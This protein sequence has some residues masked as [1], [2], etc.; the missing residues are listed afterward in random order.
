MD[1]KKKIPEIYNSDKAS[2]KEKVILGLTASIDS[3][4]S[5][6]LLKV[7][8]YELIALT[9]V[10]DWAPPELSSEKNFSCFISQDRLDFLKSFCHH[11]NIPHYIDKISLDFKDS[12][13]DP[14]IADKIVGKKSHACWNCHELRLS[15]LDQKR[16]EF[17][18]H[19]IATG[20][21]AKV[22]KRDQNGTVFV[23]SSNDPEFDQSQK[24]S[25][26]P[27]DILKH[28]LLPLSDLTRK[29][30]LKLAENFAIRNESIS[31]AIDFCFSPPPFADELITRE[32]PARFLKDG[33]VIS[34]DESVHFGQHDEMFRYGIGEIYPIKVGVQQVENH[35]ASFSLVDKKI[36]LIEGSYFSRTMHLLVNCHISQEV[37][38]SEPTK[39]FILFESEWTECLVTQ[40]TLQ[41]VSLEFE[42]EIKL[43]PGER[44]AV[45][46]KSGRNSKVLLTGDVQILPL[47]V[48][49]EGENDDSKIDPLL[50]F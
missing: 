3:M 41:A 2:R 20:H 43:L 38:L 47:P 5:A 49:L 31:A 19:F 6:Y 7:Q 10:P 40:K 33:E 24:L 36:R 50:D 23:H 37:F 30:V 1:I 8:K 42:R 18:A 13:I 9:V 34:I 39:G 29:E 45:F 28:L 46:K 15:R 25:R 35:I 48:V 26:I 27:E 32:V 4:V 21:Y 44:V 16:L 22:F 17:N 12:V 11:L 14:W